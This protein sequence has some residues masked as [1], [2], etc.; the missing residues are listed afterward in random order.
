[1]YAG[2]N[3][4]RIPPND[5]A[6]NYDRDRNW[7]RGK[8]DLNN[9]PDNTNTVFLTDSLL[10]SYG[11]SSLGIWKCPGD[12]STSKHGGKV[13]PRVR[14]VSMNAYFNFNDF[15][16]SAARRKVSGSTQAVSQNRRHDRSFTLGIWVV[17]D[18]R[19]SISNG[20][21]MNCMD[22]I[23]PRNPSQFGW[24]NWP[25]NYP[26]TVPADSTLPMAILRF[27]SGSILERHRQKEKLCRATCSNPSRTP[28]NEDSYWLGVRTTALR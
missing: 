18:E 20:H 17:I 10:A 15:C 25:A 23:Y 19:E 6:A 24:I 13:Y 28:N 7:V 14:S 26:T 2:D 5:V 8:L 16:I 12:K 21:F 11:A 27:T 4:D 9:H 1:M 3:D 22:G